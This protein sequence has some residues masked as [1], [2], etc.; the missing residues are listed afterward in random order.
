M[1]TIRVGVLMGGRSVEREVSLN[2]GRTVC[3]HLDSTQYQVIPLFQTTSG[4]LYIM[5]LRFLHRGKI[6]DFEHRLAAEA[7]SIK[8]DDLRRLIDFMFIALHGRNGEDGTMQGMLEVLRIPYFGSK[9]LASALGMDKLIQRVFLNI[10][11]I[12]M[13]KYTA[14]YP[15]EENISN[16]ALTER[17]QQVGL[18]F[19][20]MVKPSCEGSSIGITKARNIDTLREA[21]KTAMYVNTGKKQPVLIEETLTGMEFSCIVITDYASKEFIPLPPTEIEIEAGSDLFDYEQKYMPGRATKHTPARCPAETLEA[22]QRVC[23]RTMHALGFTNLGRIDGF[24]TTDG[25]IV[26]VD[27]NSFSGMAPSSYAFLQAAEVDMSHRTFINHLIKTELE[28]KS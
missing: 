15:H 20:V 9:V 16:T 22:I 27:P 26:I 7:Q 17:L 10:A 14:V 2:S 11:G 3:D 25:R 8:W 5:P 12:E 21:I 18:S 23:V 13:P 19:P 28:R 24:L 6:S 1:E 4:E